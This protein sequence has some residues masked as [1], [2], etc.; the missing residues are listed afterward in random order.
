LDDDDLEI[1]T[2]NLVPDAPP[3]PPEP[4]VDV[5][6]APEGDRPVDPSLDGAATEADRELNTLLSGFQE[7]V[8]RIARVIHRIRS[9]ELFR[10]LGYE[11][12]EAYIRSKELRMSRSFIYQLAKVGE[13]IENAG[14]DPETQP[15]AKDL[16]IS[17]LAQIARLP[18]PETHRKVLETGRITLRNEDGVE[19]DLP[20]NDVPVKKLNAHIN[21]ALGLPPRIGL[22]NDPAPE[23]GFVGAGA[24]GVQNSAAYQTISVAERT[25]PAAGSWRQTLD[26]LAAELRALPEG[27]RAGAIAEVIQVCQAMTG[28]AVPF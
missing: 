20:L 13:V 9:Q 4:A 23:P 27:E 24:T 14:I 10:N 16:Q 3:P 25:V 11:S 5:L 12:F 19:E 7:Q 15:A 2:I 22:A 28:D 26:A 1:E 8:T 17:K 21:E 18:D 6:P